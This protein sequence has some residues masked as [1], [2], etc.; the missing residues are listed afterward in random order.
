MAVR[1]TIKAIPL[2]HIDSATM[3]GAYLPIN[4][5]GFPFP[6]S[7]IRILN[8]SNTAVTLSYDGVTDHDFIPAATNTQIVLQTNA[9]PSSYS[10]VMPIGTIVYVKSAAGVGLI[11]IAGYYTPQGI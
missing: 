1:N 10:A 6:I 7:I 9:Q 8:E 5:L 3:T 2:T 4:P 11:Y